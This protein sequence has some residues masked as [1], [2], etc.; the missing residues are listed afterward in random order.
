MLKKI[1]LIIE[2]IWLK[3][4]LKMFFNYCLENA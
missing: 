2:L 1:K 4:D 3:G